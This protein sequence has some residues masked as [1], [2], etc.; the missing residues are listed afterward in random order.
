M[1]NSHLK[2]IGV[3]S[4]SEGKKVGTIDRAY[5][6]PERRSVV[7]FVVH[8]GGGMLSAE[9]DRSRIVDASDV[10]S[11]GP[12]ALMIQDESALRGDELTTPDADL[13][14]LD[15]LATRK[16]VTEGGTRVGDVAAI[17]V[18]EQSFALRSVEI[19]PGFFQTNRTIPADQVVSVGLDVLVVSDAVCETEA[20]PG[21]SSTSAAGGRHFVVVDERET[22]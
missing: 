16:V 17:D 11:L 5:F 4:I 6:D 12:D 21:D 18:D 20:N 19:S 3:I 2:G 7:S 10:H 1:K 13:M 8:E 15:E 22:E 9:P 14:E